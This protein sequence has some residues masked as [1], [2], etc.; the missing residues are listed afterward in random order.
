MAGTRNCQTELVRIFDTGIKMGRA[1][2]LLVE[3][4]ISARCGNESFMHLHKWDAR[5]R[6]A[7]TSSVSSTTL[8]SPG[9]LAVPGVGHWARVS[10]SPSR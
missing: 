10:S 6:R 7:S 4:G 2:N 5:C 1:P 9:S 3:Q 8:V